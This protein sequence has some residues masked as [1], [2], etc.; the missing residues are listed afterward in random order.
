MYL[1]RTSL[2]ALLAGWGFQRIRVLHLDVAA[3]RAADVLGRAHNVL[4]HV[5]VQISLASDCN[6]TYLWRVLGALGVALLVLVIFVVGA[7]QVI[8]RPGAINR[9]SL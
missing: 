6:R 7:A 4:R 8:A 2:H 5:L 3:R 1:A 9:H